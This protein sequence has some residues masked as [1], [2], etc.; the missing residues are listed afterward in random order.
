[1][2]DIAKALKNTTTDVHINKALDVII[3]FPLKALGNVSG[4][5]RFKEPMK[6]VK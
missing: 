1:M 2:R 3:N 6:Y 5:T 4:D